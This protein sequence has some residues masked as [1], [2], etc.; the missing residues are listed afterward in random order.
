MNQIEKKR[1]ILLFVVFSLLFVFFM[2]VVK[3]SDNSTEIQV[4]KMSHTYVDS[5]FLKSYLEQPS[6]PVND[7]LTKEAVIELFSDVEQGIDSL[8]DQK[9]L[10]NYKQQGYSLVEDSITVYSAKTSEYTQFTFLLKNGNDYVAIA[11]NYYNRTKKAI[12]IAT[13]DVHFEIKA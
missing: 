11:G 10:I 2:F 4:E 6:Q 8:S 5:D 9:Q 12:L 1:N 13:H 7:F 3:K